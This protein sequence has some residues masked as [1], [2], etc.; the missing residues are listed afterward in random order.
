MKKRYAKCL[1][2]KKRL[3]VRKDGKLPVHEERPGI[4]HRRGPTCML[5]EC[6][7]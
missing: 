5:S 2:C 6:P 3:K 4:L 7:P 1:H